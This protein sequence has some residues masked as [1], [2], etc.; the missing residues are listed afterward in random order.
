MKILLVLCAITLLLV[1]PVF[2]GTVV[3]PVEIGGV[4]VLHVTPIEREIVPGDIES[5]F[6]AQSPASY[7]VVLDGVAIDGDSVAVA[8]DAVVTD[9]TSVRLDG[10]D[11]LWSSVQYRDHCLVTIN[12]TWQEADH[13]LVFLNIGWISMYPKIHER[14]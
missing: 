7:R 12:A 6:E 3:N 5:I 8:F 1:T 4:G 9:S 13:R 11:D 14:H 10:H 2:A